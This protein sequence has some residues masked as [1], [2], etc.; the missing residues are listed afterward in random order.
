MLGETSNF[1]LELQLVNI[2][3]MTNQPVYTFHIFQTLQHAVTATII[4]V[5]VGKSTVP[6]ERNEVIKAGLEEIQKFIQ[7]LKDASIRQKETEI[8]VDGG[9]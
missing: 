7:T 5:E 9:S 4:R 8:H 2:D 6:G 3:T 1:S